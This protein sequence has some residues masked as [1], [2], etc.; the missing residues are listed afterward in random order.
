MLITH[1]FG[2]NNV[3]EYVQ[4]NT[5]FLLNNSQGNFLLLPSDNSSKTRYQGFFYN[6]GEN[7]YKTIAGIH[8][9]TEEKISEVINQFDSVTRKYEKITEKFYLTSINGSLVYEL[10]KKEDIFLDLDFRSAYQ[11]PEFGRMHKIWKERN[12]VIVE[13]TQQESKEMRGFKIY[14]VINGAEEYS[15]INKWIKQENS[16]DKERGSLPFENYVLQAL[17]LTGK[18]FCFAVSVD[19]NEAI[20]NSIKARSKLPER[21]RIL[22]ENINDLEANFALFAAKNSLASLLINRSANTHAKKDYNDHKLGIYAGLP[23]FFQFWSRDELISSKALSLIN[24]DF[25]QVSKDLVLNKLYSLKADD[26]RL[27]NILENNSSE[28]NQV[29]SSSDATGW[30]FFRLSELKNLSDKEKKLIKDFLIEYLKYQLKKFTK[31]SL[32]YSKAFE[33]WMD[34]SSDFEKKI[35]SREG[36]P[37]EIQALR[38]TNY[39]Y[40][41]E[42][43]KDDKWKAFEHRLKEKVRELYFNGKYLHDN[44][45]LLKNHDSTIRPNLFIA[46]YVYPQ[47]LTKYEWE[48]CFDAIIPEL[49]L[50]WKAGGG[51]STI[52]KHNNLFQ[53]NYS[54][55]NPVSY[56]RGDSWFWINYLAG[57]CMLRV[58]KQKYKYYVNKILNAAANDILWKGAIGHSSELSSASSQKAQGSLC[59]AWSSAMFIELIEEFKTT[60]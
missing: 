53:E 26:S 7:I 43:T 20:K 58:N 60:F 38:L 17:R 35:D 21:K 3:S 41:Y 50:N 22:F 18:K 47:L 10:N 56:H 27:P 44:I 28:K 5:F 9:D 32:A 52:D 31:N 23:W 14:L 57:I 6:D 29:N 25:Q 37:I 39:S 48:K 54:G 30:L 11:N 13:Y 59:Q 42:L 2:K 40:A 45:D 16:F 15:E 51:F 33:T 36:F 46:C 34:S 49:W 19:K 4:E 24:K 12:C 8:L 55:E 1:S